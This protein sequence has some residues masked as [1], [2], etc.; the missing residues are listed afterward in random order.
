MVAQ[1]AVSLLLLV[2]AGLVTRS[3]EAARRADR[4]FDPKQVTAIE[5]DVKQ[6]GYDEPRGRV[7]YR[8]LLE[9][10]RAEPGIES[11]TLADATTR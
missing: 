2:G 5:V 9:A 11:A 10:A 8:R 4:G 3:L 7:F 1:V 6:N